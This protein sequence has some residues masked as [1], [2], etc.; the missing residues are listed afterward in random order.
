LKEIA[1]AFG[2]LIDIDGL[3]RNRTFG[4]YTHI[5]VDIDLSKRAYD[6]ILVERYGFAFNVE[7]QYERKPLFCHHCYFIG[8]NVSTC[9]WIHL[10]AAKE[11]NDRGKQPIVAEAAAPKPTRQQHDVGTSTSANE[12][13][14]S[15][16]PIPVTSIVTTTQ[17]TPIPCA[18]ISLASQTQTISALSL[19]QL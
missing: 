14:W 18:S 5:L 9:Q 15:W 16:V 8:H 4:H 3:T 2:T 6:E 17:R 1:S 7:V 13:T 12:S 19:P 10:Q 11:K